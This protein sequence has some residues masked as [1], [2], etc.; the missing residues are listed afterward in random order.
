MLS[1]RAL[2]PSAGPIGGDGVRSSRRHLHTFNCQ[3][4]GSLFLLSPLII[5]PHDVALSYREGPG[6]FT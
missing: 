5:A 6:A 3:V 2:K 4:S 1:A